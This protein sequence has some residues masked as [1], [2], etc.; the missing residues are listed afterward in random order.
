MAGFSSASKIA[1][2]SQLS[3]LRPLDMKYYICGLLD[4]FDSRQFASMSMDGN[5]QVIYGL[6][7]NQNVQRAVGE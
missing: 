4:Y 5:N 7:Y 1:A 2:N 3:L 6:W